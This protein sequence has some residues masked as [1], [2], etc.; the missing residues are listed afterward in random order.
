MFYNSKLTAPFESPLEEQFFSLITPYLK[1]P[2]LPQYAVDTICFSFRFDF[3]IRCETH[4]IGI[5]LDGVTTHSE[6]SRA[7]DFWRDS[8]LLCE[9]HATIIYRLSGSYLRKYL[10]HAVLELLTELPACMVLDDPQPLHTCAP[11]VP[12]YSI[13]PGTLKQQNRQT[14]YT[15]ISQQNGGRLNPLIYRYK[16]TYGDLGITC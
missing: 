4:K 10:K 5:E 11:A 2:L 8:V 1:K 3:F 16:K 14:I 15:F 6:S 13:T 9:E 7:Y 12:L